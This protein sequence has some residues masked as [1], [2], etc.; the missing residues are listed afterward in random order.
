MFK[1]DT[2]RGKSSVSE[3]E[4]SERGRLQVENGQL[5]GNLGGRIK[6]KNRYEP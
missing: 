1:G 6:K 3:G 4:G 5:H 2:T